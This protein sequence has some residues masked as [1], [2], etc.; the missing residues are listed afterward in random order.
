M[1]TGKEINWNCLKKTL[2]KT[3]SDKVTTWQQISDFH[4]WLDACVKPQQGQQAHLCAFRSESTLQ[5]SW[6]LGEAFGQTGSWHIPHKCASPPNPTVIQCITIVIKWWQLWWNG[7]S[8]R[9]SK[10]HMALRGGHCWHHCMFF[11]SGWTTNIQLKF[12]TFSHQVLEYR[13]TWN[14]M[15]NQVYDVKCL[16]CHVFVFVIW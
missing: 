7:R 10:W 1:P 9:S 8:S 3:C 16:S 11:T 5:L 12:L 14:K 15:V 13:E 6:D 2:K 4:T